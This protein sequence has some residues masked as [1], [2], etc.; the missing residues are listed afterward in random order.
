MNNVPYKI[1]RYENLHDDAT[2]L[3][4]ETKGSTSSERGIRRAFMLK[5]PLHFIH[6]IL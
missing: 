1:I 3:K 4:S 6:L 5:Q 2:T